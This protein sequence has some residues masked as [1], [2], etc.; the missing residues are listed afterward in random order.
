MSRLTCVS[1]IAIV[2]LFGGLPSTP[3]AAAAGLS[4]RQAA[5]VRSQ[6]PRGRSRRSRRGVIIVGVSVAT[7]VI[8]AVFLWRRARSETSGRATRAREIAEQIGLTYEAR[9]PKS[10]RKDFRHLPQIKGHGQV[11][12]VLRGTICDRPLV[13]FEYSYLVSA[14]QVMVTMAYA[15]YALDAPDHWPRLRISRSNY[16][17]RLFSRL[18]FGRQLSLESSRFNATMRV[19]TDDEDF[20]IAILSPEMQSFLAEKPTVSWHLGHGRLCLIYHGHLR[21]QRVEASIDRLQRF[22]SLL[23]DEVVE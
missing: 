17:T 12:H 7:A 20:A 2:V 13:G 22:W 19:R 18:G 8:F 15:I 10:L 5:T 9:G 4:D 11:K 21:M 1:L 6:V 16:F 23:P 14:G 3:R